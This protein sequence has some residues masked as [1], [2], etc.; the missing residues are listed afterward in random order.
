M[1]P[2]PR[3]T[4]SRRVFIKRAAGLAAFTFAAFAAVALMGL[5]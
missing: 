1:T 3:W 4:P 5:G 2:P